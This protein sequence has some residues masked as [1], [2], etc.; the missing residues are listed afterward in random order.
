[1][2][3]NDG[4]FF[5]NV[6]SVQKWLGEKSPSDFAGSLDAEKG[7]FTRETRLRRCSDTSTILNFTVQT[8]RKPTMKEKPFDDKIIGSGG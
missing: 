5:S 8:R 7:K 1:M 3:L 4:V 6:L 2:N